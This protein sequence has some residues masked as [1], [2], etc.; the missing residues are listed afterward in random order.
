MDIKNA[1]FEQNTNNLE[2][3]PV[4]TGCLTND[5]AQQH[6]AYRGLNLEKHLCVRYEIYF[7]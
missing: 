2:Y 3:T 1:H 6:F 4:Y 5:L 7:S